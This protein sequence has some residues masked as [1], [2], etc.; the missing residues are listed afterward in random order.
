MTYADAL[1]LLRGCRDLQPTE[2]QVL[3]SGAIVD[4]LL[5]DSF[6]ALVSVAKEI[7]AR[8]YPTDIFPVA[9]EDRR[10][11]GVRLVTALHAVVEVLE[12]RSAL[13]AEYAESLIQMAAEEAAYIAKGRP[14]V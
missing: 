8:H 1:K 12:A 3:V 4:E 2:L 13:K 11:P 6:D 7:L 5:D 9:V 14:T 10:D